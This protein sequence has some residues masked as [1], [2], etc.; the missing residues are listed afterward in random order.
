LVETFIKKGLGSAMSSWISTGQNL[1]V[2]GDQ[3]QQVL[4]Q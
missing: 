1:P 4:G 3:I 2:T